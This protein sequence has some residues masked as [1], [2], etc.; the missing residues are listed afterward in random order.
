[1]RSDVE[2]KYITN[3]GVKEKAKKRK[4]NEEKMIKKLEQEKRDAQN[5]VQLEKKNSDEK[6]NSV[7]NKKFD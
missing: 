6:G 2:Y 3:S 7:V 4:W 1:L 5:K